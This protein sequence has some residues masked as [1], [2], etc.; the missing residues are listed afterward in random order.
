MKKLLLI[1]LCLIM[2]FTFCACSSTQF[3][4]QA[5]VNKLV[6][7][8]SNNGNLP[9]MEMTLSYTSTSDNTSMRIKVVYDLLLDKAPIS[10]I[11]FINLLNSGRYNNVVVDSKST[12]YMS[13]GRFTYTVPSDDATTFN[14]RS[15]AFADTSKTF[16]GEFKNNN[17]KPYGKVDDDDDGYV[18]FDLFSLAMY[19]DNAASKSDEKEQQTEYR[20]AYNSADGRLMLSLGTTDSGVAPSYKDYAVFARPV[21]I[22]YSYDGGQTYAAPVSILDSWALTQLTSVSSKTKSINGTNYSPIQIDVSFQMVAGS[23]DWANIKEN[24]L[25]EAE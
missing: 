14:D 22:S 23:I 12:A 1:A 13:I 17:F 16:I 7:K 10:V 8:Y 19:H 21:S 3:L 6:K 5:Q 15:F 25:V 4:S 18:K 9:Q 20:R 24:Y 2:M 11:S